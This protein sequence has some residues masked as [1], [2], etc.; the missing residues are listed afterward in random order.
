MTPRRHLWIWCGLADTAL[1]AAFAML[2]KL[3]I[4]VALAP[5]SFPLRAWVDSRQEGQ[6]FID[7]LF[8][9]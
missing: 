8:S 2:L 6:A 7:R 4:L 3:P 9:W 1:C 5:L